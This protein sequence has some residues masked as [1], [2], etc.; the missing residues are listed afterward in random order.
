ME[1]TI[2]H[3]NEAHAEYREMG[4]ELVAES[5]GNAQEVA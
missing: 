3:Y 5:S 4:L 1:Q 2:A